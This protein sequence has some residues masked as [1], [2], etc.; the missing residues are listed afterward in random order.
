MQIYTP[1]SNTMRRGEVHERK[2]PVLGF[3]KDHDGMIINSS[4]TPPSIRLLS[5]EL[6]LPGGGLQPDN[7]LYTPSPTRIDNTTEMMSHRLIIKDLSPTRH[8]NIETPPTRLI[9][10]H[11]PPTRLKNDTEIS[12]A[13]LLLDDQGTVLIKSEAYLLV[14]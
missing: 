8:I 5:T 11:T 12:S 9:N 13:R 7:P 2:A 4:P 3:V 6:Q 10:T 14:A 1:G